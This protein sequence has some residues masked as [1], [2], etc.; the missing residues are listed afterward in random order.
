[1]YKV[2]LLVE[3]SFYVQAFKIRSRIADLMATN[4]DLL[5]MATFYDLVLKVS[6]NIAITLGMKK[7]RNSKNIMESNM[8]TCG[9]AGFTESFI[10]K[11]LLE[12]K[13]FG[14]LYAGQP[15]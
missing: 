8:F 2:I 11:S 14:H 9:T 6:I 3:L 4:Q 13:Y 10:S 15:R 1:M 5:V 12:V 7:K